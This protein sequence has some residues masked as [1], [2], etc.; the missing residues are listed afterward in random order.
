MLPAPEGR[1]TMPRTF[2]KLITHAIF[3]TQDRQPL[4]TPDRR[5]DLLIWAALSAIFTVS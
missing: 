1:E 2:A 3:S 5:P 4:L